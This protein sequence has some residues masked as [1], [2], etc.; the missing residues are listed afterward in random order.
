MYI[1]F[2]RLR[3]VYLW[4]HLFIARRPDSGRAPSDFTDFFSCAT[5]LLLFLPGCGNVHSGQIPKLIHKYVT[6]YTLQLRCVVYIVLL[7]KPRQRG[8]VLR[9]GHA[10]LI[11]GRD[12]TRKNPLL[13]PAAA[14]FLLW[15]VRA[16]PCMMSTFPFMLFLLCGLLNDGLSSLNS[17]WFSFLA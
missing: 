4:Q 17:V 14:F 9:N 13:C 16:A 5:Y 2:K 12:A 3:C 15:L 6:C 1:C 8:S 11:L 10:A 7:L